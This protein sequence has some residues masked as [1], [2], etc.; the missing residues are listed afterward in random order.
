MTINEQNKTVVHEF[1][2]ALFTK[3]D[4]SAVDHYLADDFV[5][6]DSALPDAT[7]DSAGF[8]DAAAR[9]RAA[10][11]D[12]H[13]D[14]HL[15]IA[16]GDLVAEH[17]TASGTHRGEIMG[18]A[19]TNRVVTVP[20]INIFRLRDGKIVERW[21]KLDMLGFFVQLGLVSLPFPA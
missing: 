2:Q 7:P 18:V 16:E 13:S 1:I 5:A 10:F 20:G 17:F 19:P 11:P 8:R 3:G 9:I 21:G 12:W 6:H 4:L 15:L 14:V